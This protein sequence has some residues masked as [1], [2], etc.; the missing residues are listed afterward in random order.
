MRGLLRRCAVASAALPLAA[1]IAVT[2]STN[3][4]AAPP[5][6]NLVTNGGFETGDFTGWTQSVTTGM[7]VATLPIIGLTTVYDGTHVALLSS[8]SSA[9]LSQTVATQKNKTYRLTYHI[10]MGYSAGSSVSIRGEVMD[11]ATT[12]DYRS[13]SDI[14]YTLWQE[15]TFTFK[16]ISSSTTLKFTFTNPSGYWALDGVSVVILHGK[17]PV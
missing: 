1:A 12:L 10:N 15:R 7:S 3:A 11:G 9:D 13:D 16:A 4:T 2:A 14:T 6:K 8:A 17:L 5:I